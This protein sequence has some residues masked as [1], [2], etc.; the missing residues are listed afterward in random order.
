MSNLAELYTQLRRYD[1]SDRLYRRALAIL[2]S[3]LGPDHSEIAM[4]LLSLA[5]GYCLQQHYDEAE[6]LFRRALAISEKTLGPGHPLV[7]RTL[8]SY[9]RLLRATKRKGEAGQLEQRARAIASNRR[10]ETAATALTVDYGELR[11]ST[12]RERER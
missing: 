1:E 5:E 12:F 4:A 9:A 8:A 11:G 7:G 10:Q 3:A 6:P 2:E